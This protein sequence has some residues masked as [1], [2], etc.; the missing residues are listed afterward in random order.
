[1]KASSSDRAAR[2]K[3]E[4]IEWQFDAPNLGEVERFVESKLGE[5]A[6]LSLGP[7][8]DV[9]LL[10]VYFDSE[11]LRFLRAGFAFRARLR[12][13]DA[14][15][16]QL[17][18]KS[19]TPPKGNLARRREIEQTIEA[20][21]ERSGARMMNEAGEWIARALSLEGMV[22]SRA[23][24]LLGRG[25][26]LVLFGLRQERRQRSLSGPEGEAGELA[27]DRTQA[28]DPR[29]ATH[30]DSFQRVELELRTDGASRQAIERL[31]SALEGELGLTGPRVAKFRAGLAA[32]GRDLARVFDFGQT[33][34]S[35]DPAAH[36][37]AYG[38]LRAQ[39]AQL[40]RREPGTRLGED[41]EELHQMRVATR[42]IRAALSLFADALPA[43]GAAHR[44]RFRGLGKLLGVARDLDIQLA[45]FDAARRRATLESALIQAGID[46]WTE[47]LR[48][49][50]ASAQRAIE[51][52]LDSPRYAGMIERFGRF[53]RRGAPRSHEEVEA[54]RV[55]ARREVTKRHRKL[56]RRLRELEPST[57]APMLHEARIAGKKLRYALEFC[58]PLLEPESKRY[59]K[60]LVALQDLLGGVQ[61]GEVG[62]ELLR[63]RAARLRGEKRVELLLAAGMLLERYRRQG[64]KLRAGV[65]RAVERLRGKVWTTLKERLEAIAP[66][67]KEE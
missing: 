44:A 19:L 52:L 11:D 54:A 27:L 35:L 62:S 28:L 4:E 45:T 26:L 31:A 64:M 57:P 8:L 41:E 32:S 39:L 34:P 1:M 58:A 46:G 13:A 29:G 36:E 21:P 20:W 7:A 61:D 63:Q 60:R 10:D 66:E 49:R 55:L 25:E 12:E 9:D 47:L 14:A 5:G 17:T 6:D 15:S 40:L 24:G 18:L 22:T 43:A 59:V 16:I 48:K 51:R 42:R 67:E 23:R 53:L 2:A 38:A 50:R 37:L 56:K 3:Q 65:P 30:G 33:M